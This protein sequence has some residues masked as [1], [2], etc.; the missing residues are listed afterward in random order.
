MDEIFNEDDHISD[1]GFNKLLQDELNDLELLEIA[2]HLSFCD[3]CIEKYSELL[4]NVSLLSPPETFINRTLK[5]IKQKT[6]RLIY[7]KYFSAAVAAGF[8]IFLWVSGIFNI[9]VEALNKKIEIPVNKRT[10]ITDSFSAKF[11]SIVDKLS[12]LYEDKEIGG[13]YEKK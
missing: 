4:N 7:N 8:A 12:S 11:N 9:N 13:S 2:E 6:I 10:S 1:Y 5:A 3:E